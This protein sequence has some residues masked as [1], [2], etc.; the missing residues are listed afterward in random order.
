MRQERL[1]IE[2][3]SKEIFHTKILDHVS[4]RLF[5]GE[6]AALLGANGAGKTVLMEVLAGV[7]P[8]DEGQFYYD[9]YPVEIRTPQDAKRLK[10][11]YIP[12][13]G[14][15]IDS[16]TVFDNLFF[17]N[18][19][20]FLLNYQKKKRE[21]KELLERAGLS[22]QL[23]Y[24]YRKLETGKK[25]LIKLAAAM[26]TDPK[27]LIMD[28]PFSF[29]DRKERANMLEMLRQMKEQGTSILLTSHN[30]YQA[31]KIA[32]RGMVLRDGILVGTFEM[33]AVS[34]EAV[35]SMIAGKLYRSS[36]REE[37]TAGKRIRLRVEDLSGEGISSANFCLHEGEIL[38]ITGLSG[39]GR[40]RIMD[41]LF[42][43]KK[44]AGGKIYLDGS[45]IEIS[46]PED[47]LKY[48]IAYASN[49]EGQFGVIDTLSVQENVVLPS[50]KKVSSAGYVHEWQCRYM[51]RHYLGLLT[52]GFPASVA[53][54][55]GKIQDAK[56]PFTDE[57][58]NRPVQELSLGFYQLV[59]LAQCLSSSPKVL[60]LDH[61]TLGLDTAAR[62]KVHALMRDLSRQGVSIM[63]VSDEIEEIT[64]LSH[65]FLVLQNG[66]LTGE[67]AR[68]E[69]EESIWQR[70]D[71]I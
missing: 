67:I 64:A 52:G 29:L 3:V 20:R 69:I 33:D 43:L 53:Q 9:E 24:R 36:R 21:A 10:I 47:A 8:R 54:T 59:K 6:T 31:R 44:K 25:K 55:Y 68:E 41:L 71:G 18:D 7:V 39:S 23:N 12:E 65:R 30:I 45:L 49:K 17:E 16:L 63:F 61:P 5:A 70:G 35:L 22:L 15:Y 14:G 51:A 28:E 38:G 37:N 42:G 2:N 56:P 32:D 1:R 34:E 66:V 26:R 13:N 11:Q 50:L 27:I 57:Y 58:L 60:L 48:R 19:G 46:S 4:L 40:T 62:E